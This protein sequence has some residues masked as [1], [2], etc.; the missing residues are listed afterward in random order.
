MFISCRCTRCRRPLRL[1][2]CYAGKTLRCPGC[3]ATVVIPMDLAAPR[4]NVGAEAKRERA[5]EAKAVPAGDALWERVILPW[6]LLT[7]AA[8]TLALLVWSGQGVLWA[9]LGVG[10]GGLCLLV[11]QASRWPLSVR[12]IVSLSLAL[13]GHGL[14]LAAPLM[15]A[16]Q[17][18]SSKVVHPSL[19]SAPSAAGMLPPPHEV[20]RFDRDSQ[21]AEMRSLW[22]RGRKRDLFPRPFVPD[23]Q[24]GTR[25]GD[26][27]AVA[28]APSP[29]GDGSAFVTT[30]D[31]LLKDFS[32]P[33]FQ[34]R[35]AYRLEQP[36]Y[37]AAL[38]DRRALLWTAACAPAN[39]RVNRHGD[40]PLG[41]GDLHVYA[42]P[43][44]T[45]S[46]ATT[47][48]E[49]H[50]HRV[51]PVAGDVLELLIAPDQQALFYLARTDDGVYLARIDAERQA[52]DRQV[53]LADEIRALCLTADGKTLYA[54]GGGMV[55]VFNPAS[56]QLLRRVDVKADVY[57]IAADNEGG[58][59]L[60]EQGQ[61]TKL[62]RLDL[63]GPQAIVRQWIAR[64]H[65]RIYLKLAPDQYRLYVGT[66]SV[67][68]DHLDS[69]LIHGHS[70]DT[71]LVTSMAVSRPQTPVQ[72]EF[73]LTPDGSFLIN[74]WGSVFRLVRGE[75][76]MGF[77][78]S[79]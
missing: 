32:Y 48:A 5:R 22:L 51:L 11:G 62:T 37:R 38:D 29:S 10:L 57:A 56:L 42:L 35:A 21:L 44:S 28:V 75:P 55:C 19:F 16:P 39:L 34:L 66:S 54:A 14:T 41:R 68:S 25:L 70:W 64:L 17:S 47:L 20:V 61:W 33:N 78:V 18:S 58:V 72:G 73:F 23:L 71:P 13:L 24:P 4:R 9:G 6:L 27:L 79:H 15:S 69:L 26:L 63:R 67:I 53:R 45:R 46:R 77:G 74:R 43:P 59:Y 1:R 2:G 40:Q 7:P 3:A 36:A 65:G 76:P 8:L 49:L 50:P 60:A 12:V 30:A 52:V 31:G